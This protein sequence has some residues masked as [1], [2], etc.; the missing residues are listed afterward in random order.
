[1][2]RQKYISGNAK[3]MSQGTLVKLSTACSRKAKLSELRTKGKSGG[4]GKLQGGSV[5]GC[6]GC[7]LQGPWRGWG[8]KKTAYALL[9]KVTVYP[10]A[11]GMLPEVV[12]TLHPVFT[13]RLASLCKPYITRLS[14]PPGGAFSILHKGIM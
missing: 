7:D 6:G 9:S 12:T 14:V 3:N 11:E 1:M 10:T 13:Q 5:N 4:T 2:R 8:L